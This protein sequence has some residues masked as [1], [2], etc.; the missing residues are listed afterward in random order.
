MKRIVREMR[1]SG[2]PSIGGKNMSECVKTKNAS[3]CT[4]RRWNDCHD[5]RSASVEF[6]ESDDEQNVYSDNDD[7]SDNNDE[8][9]EDDYSE[10]DYYS[11]DEDGYF[12]EDMA[13]ALQRSRVETQQPTLEEEEFDQICYVKLGWRC[14]CD[15]CVNTQHIFSE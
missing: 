6:E 3:K 12:S 1:R 13:V 15:R 2:I 10:N 11:E 8:Y 14:M 9:S 7:Y 4:Q 5:N